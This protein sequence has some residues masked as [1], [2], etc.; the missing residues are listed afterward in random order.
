SP[1]RHGLPGHG[2]RQRAAGRG[3]RYLLHRHELPR[4]CRDAAWPRSRS[5]VIIAIDGPAAS[6]KGTLAKRLAEHYGRRHLDSGSIYRAVAKALLDAGHS[7]DDRARAVTAAHTLDPAQ[8]D[9]PALKSQAIGDAASL[10]SAIPEVRAALVE[11]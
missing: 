7:P 3:G 10:V 6:G 4:L 11:F 2:S 1:A 5:F 8:L 9:E